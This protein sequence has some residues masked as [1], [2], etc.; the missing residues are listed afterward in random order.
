MRS[1]PSTCSA[2]NTVNVRAN[3]D[4]G[5]RPRVHRRRAGSWRSVGF[6]NTTCV[7]RSP[8]AD[9][10]AVTLPPSVGR[11]RR[12]R[13]AAIGRDHRQ[14]PARSTRG[15]GRPSTLR[16]RP[17]RRG[18]CHGIRQFARSGLDRCHQIG[19]HLLEQIAVPSSRRHLRAGLRPLRAASATSGRSTR[20]AWPR[21]TRG[22][23]GRERRRTTAPAR[24]AATSMMLPPSP[25]RG[26]AV[27]EARR[28]ERAGASFRSLIPSTSSG[29]WPRCCRTSSDEMT[30]VRTGGVRGLL[31]ADAD[32]DRLHDELC[33][34]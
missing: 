9:L 21:G 29:R 28:A 1:A 10:A 18:D 2:A 5:A 7:P 13:P 26:L 11:P 22:L 31:R 32:G 17:P 19:G 30:T 3:S 6:H 23:T 25:V 20:R 16:G 14:G 12:R 27:S 4:A 8:R 33:V 24:R 34:D 15:S